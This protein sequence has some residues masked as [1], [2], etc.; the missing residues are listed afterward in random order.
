ML[1]MESSYELRD[2][3]PHGSVKGRGAGLNPGN[4]YEST[5]LHVLG[6]HLDLILVERSLELEEGCENNA[7]EGR[8]VIT[9]VYADHSRSILNPVDSP[10][11]GFN[12][13]INPYRGCEHGCIY[14]YARPF[15]EMLGFSCGMDFETKIMAK[16]K[17]AKMLRKEL[18]R[19]R[20]QAQM[21][22][23]SGVTDC[24]QPIEA[25]LKITRACL[26]V[27]AHCRQPVGIV[28]KNRLVLRDLD[29]LQELA[30]HRAVCVAVSVTTLDPKLARIMEPRASSPVDRLKTI[31]KLHQAGVPV[32][33]MV[34]PVI[35]AINDREIPK[36]LEAVA[37]VGAQSASYVLLRLPHQVQDLYIDWLKRYFPDRADHA[38]S[39]LRQCRHGQL[40]DPA[41]G[42]R[43][44]GSGQIARQIRQIF[45]TF[46]RRY[47]L[48]RPMPAMSNTAFRRPTTDGQMSLFE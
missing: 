45:H 3:L 1:G 17:A 28:T 38:L 43:M 44:K 9:H 19:P 37:A 18:A 30:K 26:E 33:A 21:I 14:C 15:H 40:Y 31:E 35:P 10:D 16:L 48:H 39:L 13:S 42:R 5:R 12:W 4:R 24:F 27:L 41:F 8:Q 32:L 23:M 20:W 29:L 11:I 25:K 6:E 22:A 7:S 46:K 47:H 34:A 2:T 36:I